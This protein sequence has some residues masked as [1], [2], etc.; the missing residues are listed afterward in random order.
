M[1]RMK[2]IA[3]LLVTG[4]F[5]VAGLLGGLYHDTPLG[6]SLFMEAKLGPF[7]GPFLFALGMWQAERGVS[8]VQE[9][10]C[11]PFIVAGWITILLEM[12]AMRLLYNTPQADF[13][14]GSVIVA[15][16]LLWFCIAKPDWGKGSRLVGWAGYTLGVY[17]LHP[18][19]LRI[20]RLLDFNPEWLFWQFVEPFVIYGV[21]LGL[22]MLLARIVYLRPLVR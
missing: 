6:I 2:L 12:M 4:L 7:G 10:I 20:P 21:T 17:V 19:I 11:I 5:Y 22:C 14:I 1:K 16:G 3:L 8:V 13:Y 9:R 15:L 18:T